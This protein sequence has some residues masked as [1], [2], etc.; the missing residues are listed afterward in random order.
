METNLLM[1]NESD[2]TWYLDSNPSGE[3]SKDELAAEIRARQPWRSHW[4]PSSQEMLESW[5]HC[6]FPE[7]LSWRFDR[8][9][10]FDRPWRKWT[11]SSRAMEEI[12]TELPRRQL[13]GGKTSTFCA[14]L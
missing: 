6:E 4:P 8:T 7:V 14:L 12:G 11:R 5:L 1:G 3:G 9:V 10:P 2:I 13:G